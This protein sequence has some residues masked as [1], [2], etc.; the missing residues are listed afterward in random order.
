MEVIAGASN[1]LPHI[2]ALQTE[3]SVLNI[4]EGMPSIEHVIP[5]MRDLEFDLVGMFPVNHDRDLRVIEYDAVFIN[6]KRMFQD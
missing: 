3:V 5:K 4:Y 1:S 6:R 2:C